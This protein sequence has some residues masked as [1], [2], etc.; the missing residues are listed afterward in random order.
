VKL[1][2]PFVIDSRPQ[3]GLPKWSYFKEMKA[4]VCKMMSSMSWTA[5]AISLLFPLSGTAEN[6]KS[7][8]IGGVERVQKSSMR[9]PVI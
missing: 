8:F 7:Y 4:F 2:V 3:N 1:K 5:A 9:V 6:T